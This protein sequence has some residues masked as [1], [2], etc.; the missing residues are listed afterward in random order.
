MAREQEAHTALDKL[1]VDPGDLISRLKKINYHKK[2]VLKEVAT[3]LEVSSE[4]YLKNQKPY[5]ESWQVEELLVRGHYIGA[6]S[7]DHPLYYELELEEQ[8]R[9]TM[10]SM[11]YIVDRF[12]LS[13]RIFSI[14]HVDTGIGRDFF[15]RVFND[16]ESPLD[17]IFANSNL[18]KEGEFDRV[19]HRVIGE[20]PDFDLRGFINAHLI[21]NWFDELVGRSVIIRK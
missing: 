20:N 12:N 4:D 17:L 15:R 19:I 8:I 1:Q 2:D 21:F 5:L 3:I 14:P 18:K 11:N 6:H 13:Y 16:E 10:E 9:Q 7:I